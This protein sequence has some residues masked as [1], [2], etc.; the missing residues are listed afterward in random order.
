[1]AVPHPFVVPSGTTCP[2]RSGSA[3]AETPGMK[4]RTLAAILWAL[5]GWYLGAVA[6]WLVNA[7]PLLA[8][9]G[10]LVAAYLIGVD[11]RRVIWTRPDGRS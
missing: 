1:M 6:G 2:L 4:K 10:A 11:P 9:V 7:G 3:V 8:V 5:T